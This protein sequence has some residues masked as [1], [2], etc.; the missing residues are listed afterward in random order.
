MINDITNFLPF[1]ENISENS[2]N[3]S[4]VT[5]KEFYE[6]RILDDDD[7][8]IN[9]QKLLKNQEFIARFLSDHTP[10][11]Q[12]LIFH[13]MGVGKSIASIG[14]VERIKQDSKT[15][16]NGAVIFAS[17]TNL[18]NNF[19]NEIFKYTN[20]YDFVQNNEDIDDID[21]IDDIEDNEDENGD[22]DE[23]ED[24]DE[25]TEKEQFNIQKAQKYISKKSK[26]KN[27]S[28]NIDD[29]ITFKQKRKY[30]NLKKEGFYSFETFQTFV[31]KYLLIESDETII[32][33]YS[34]KIIIM[35]EIHNIRDLT[36]ENPRNKKNKLDVYGSF[37]KF[38]HQIKNSKI[39]LLSGTPMKDKIIEIADI[40]N[41]ILPLNSQIPK[42]RFISNYFDNDDDYYLVKLDKKDELKS[43][44]NGRV[45]YLKSLQSVVKKKFIGGDEEEEEEDNTYLK[46]LVVKKSIM[47][48]KQLE[49]YIEAYNNDMKGVTKKDLENAKD[50][51]EDDETN[52]KTSQETN[53]DDE[54]DNDDEDNDDEDDEDN[55][56]EYDDDEDDEFYDGNKESLGLYSNVREASLFVFPDGSYGKKGFKK[57]IEEKKS[58]FQKQQI[59][60]YVFKDS[61]KQYFKDCKNDDERLEKLKTLSIKY[62]HVIKKI[63]SVTDDNIDS[64]QKKLSFVFCNLKNGGGTILFSLLLQLFGFEEANTNSLSSK[65]K[66][67]AL[68]ISGTTNFDQL[69]NM[70]NHQSN[71]HGEYISVII[72]SKSISEG[73]SF[74]SV[75]ECHITTPHWNY[76]ETDQAIARGYRYGSHN[77]LVQE[78]ES[79]TPE[80]K[81]KVKPPC[82][83]IYQHV[84]LQN[85]DSVESIDLIMYQRS[86][87]KDVSIKNVERILK[88]SAVDCALNYN[89]NRKKDTQNFTRDCEYTNCFYDCNYGTFNIENEE[90]VVLDYSTYNIYYFRNYDKYMKIKNY[91][92]HDIFNNYFNANYLLIKRKVTDYINDISDT[93]LL[94]ILFDIVNEKVTFRNK[95]D[96]LCY[97]NEYNNNFYI[98]DVD[99]LYSN[100]LSFYY[101]ENPD[102]TL[103][104]KEKSLEILKKHVNPNSEQLIDNFF[105][106]DLRLSKKD[107]INLI[108]NMDIKLRQLLLEK[109]LL[110]IK[111][112]ELRNKQVKNIEY[113]KFISDY[114]SDYHIDLETIVNEINYNITFTW[115][116]YDKNR[117]NLEDIR[118]LY[119]NS[120]EWKNCNKQ[121]L[122]IYKS[123]MRLDKETKNN[124][125]ENTAI[126]QNKYGLYGFNKKNKFYIHDYQKS[127]RTSGQ[128]C[129]TFKTI[130]LI[131]IIIRLNIIPKEK[132]KTWFNIKKNNIN[133]LQKIYN[134]KE[135]KQIFDDDSID[136]DN[137]KI[138]IFWYT[139]KK[140]SLCKIIFEKLTTE[141]L[142]KK[143]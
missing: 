6:Q 37:W 77:Y 71:L 139:Y 44:F 108:E 85:D 72:G 67:Y 118:C 26:G 54:E 134:H 43:F 95:Y 142:I 126:I 47:E 61:F 84:S 111:K 131:N 113:A 18:L 31:K 51:Y 91:I 136:E 109:S 105:K 82:Y 119:E 59:K 36:V 14:A 2:F 48:E 27:T 99:N 123:F 60:K 93:N 45:S 94:N 70:C 75:Q 96:R 13:E 128:V 89:R 24:E 79:L 76:A 34:N 19:K 98:L 5:K 103:I 8:S 138:Y 40:M 11:D 102:I 65:K 1:Y 21:D 49:S 12:L 22:K 53:N 88:E 3:E 130:D 78:Y 121:E 74:F 125:V 133:N 4:I 69:K 42:N 97:L 7:N 86:E 30:K 116:L 50:I 107:C 129:D 46:Y 64:L 63:L 132:D 101:I 35:D 33:D 41:L 23:D 57:F 112:K 66:R 32:E 55:Y 141:N 143:N 81:K 68:F 137:K 140:D 38:L 56:N 92:I 9:K 28:G 39:I 58:S 83:N 106:C 62:Y 73:Y 122:K 115:I 90:E 135:L 104:S 25:L 87:K 100:Y 29:F 16:F 110:A 120:N 20:R 17:G 117:K 80:I 10:Y 52:E 114:L 15:S 127:Y 124:L